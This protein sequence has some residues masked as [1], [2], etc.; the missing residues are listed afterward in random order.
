MGTRPGGGYR[1]RPVVRRV[2]LPPEELDRYRA[3]SSENLAVSL[4][5]AAAVDI[6]LRALQSRQFDGLTTIPHVD[7]GSEARVFGVALMRFDDWVADIA[8][9]ARAVDAA[10]SQ[11]SDDVIGSLIGAGLTEFVAP[12]VA[13]PPWRTSEVVSSDIVLFEVAA[14]A[15][16]AASGVF[17]FRIDRLAD[18]SVEVT[19][20][21]EGGVGAEAGVG[22]TATMG[23]GSTTVGIDVEATVTALA[24]L[25]SSRT[26]RVDTDDVDLL[27]TQRLIAAVGIGAAME[28]I[29]AALAAMPDSVGVSSDGWGLDL[30]FTEWDLPV[31]PEFDLDV[32]VVGMAELA[33]AGGF[34]VAAL[35]Y[36]PPAPVRWSTG[37]AADVDATATAS[38]GGPV[39]VEADGEL[40]ARY[41]SVEYADGS[42]SDR[43]SVSVAA[44]VDTPLG[45]LEGSLEVVIDR[46]FSPGGDLA[47]VEASWLAASGSGAEVHSV[48]F[49]VAM[50]EAGAAADATW[51]ALLDPR[52]VP[53]ALDILLGGTAIPGV[54][55][56]SQGFT[57]EQRSYGPA[58]DLAPLLG[59][60][61]V[62]AEVTVV[63]LDSR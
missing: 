22:F 11:L 38:T 32:S 40:E 43:V 54:V 21:S 39:G 14:A 6:D 49:D 59:S 63:N 4:A 45:D 42:R 50:P 37:V 27:I 17:G 29:A 47:A 9:A 25:V 13:A 15:G 8:A 19:E 52:R 28:P 46:R 24:S 30:P 7:V 33:A 23:L 53:D 51:D 26:W 5:R 61:G 41:E 35:A 44:G 12:I 57:L 3:A 36:T 18:G 2:S 60:V 56:A 20:L 62:T 31:L 1:V 58:V 10:G 48:S 55:R 16:L 34:L